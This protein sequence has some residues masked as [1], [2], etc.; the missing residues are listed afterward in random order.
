MA[1]TQ[2]Q[3]EKQPLLAEEGK[4]GAEA[5]KEDQGP[6]IEEPDDSMSY[7]ARKLLSFEICR[8]FSGTVWAKASLW[9][10]MGILLAISIFV[11][12]LVAF[13]VR[14]PAQLDVSKFQTISSFLRVIV[15]LLLG[16]F[17]SSSVARWYSCTNGFLELFD[18][19]RGVQM[20][21]NALGVPK[22]RV[23]LCIR[24]CILSAN[25]L[26]IDLKASSL[27]PKERAAYYKEK[28]QKMLTTDKD[29]S[30]AWSDPT[31][32]L[33]TVS[34][35]EFETL[36]DLKD[37]AQTLWV[38]VTSLLSRMAADGEI[39]PMPTPTYGR[40]IAIAEKAY[41]GIRMVRKNIN[42]QPPYVHVQMLAMIVAVN[43]LI[44]A[45]GLGMT[46]G[47]TVA[48]Y[49]QRLK[50]GTAINVDD[51]AQ[52]LQDLLITCILSIVGPFLYQALLEVTMSIVQPFGDADKG[53]SSP[54]RIPTEKL[55]YQLEKDLRDTETMT[56]NLPWW[57]Q[58]HFK[59][60]AN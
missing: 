24:Y 11:S 18:A 31:A 23:H 34:E 28:W 5:E 1:P 16:F 44:S 53:T 33:S 7:D 50:K 40:I 15:G 37:P 17:L 6:K 35:A 49:V 36:R 56:S 30:V 32:S 52:D 2:E 60:P 25:C 39:P 45:I 4:A 59:Q 19:I 29:S 51:T 47:V 38:W 9:K 41:S 14:N 26:S 58:P 57:D 48:A 27:R 43:N 12:I 8:D 22:E 3:L 21:L 42:V 54:G 46:M 13:C 20:Q 55:M 10:V